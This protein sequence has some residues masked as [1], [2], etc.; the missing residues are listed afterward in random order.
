MANH[1]LDGKPG[2][3]GGLMVSKDR[4]GLDEEIFMKVKEGELHRSRWHD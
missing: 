3:E 2:S 4:M 1:G